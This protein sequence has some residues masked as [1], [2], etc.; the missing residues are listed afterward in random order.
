MKAET[1]RFLITLTLVALAGWIGGN[2]LLGAPGLSRDYLEAHRAEH[3]HYLEVIKSESYRRYMQRPHLVDLAQDP[4]LQQRIDYVN[5]Y[6]SGETFVSEQHRVELR[7]LFF[8]FFNAALVVVL[9]LKLGRKPLLDFID[10]Q[11]TTI[12]ERLNQAARSRKAATARLTAAQDKTAHIHEEEMRISAQ[13][14][15][16]LEREMAELA[17]ANHYSFG[18]HERDLVERKKAAEH[19]AEL[20]VR[21]ALVDRAIADLTAQHGKNDG[22]DQQDRY[23]QQFIQGLEAGR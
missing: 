16:R 12:R 19:A 8:E 10:G 23:I 5:A 11:T 18:L 1:K 14:E 15:S 22:P 17:N 13:T 21:I 3:D 20:A 9:I 4:T 2:W 7:N 6:T